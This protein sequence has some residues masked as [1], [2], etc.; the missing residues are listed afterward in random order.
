MARRVVPV[1]RRMNGYEKFIVL[2]G[3][4]VRRI[5]IARCHY[6]SWRMCAPSGDRGAMTRT[7]TVWSLASVC[8]REAR[9]SF[10]R[11][12]QSGQRLRA[13][14]CIAPQPVVQPVE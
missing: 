11:L 13:D 6:G 3:G 4:R 12:G 7:A 1:G 8:G 14:A 10:G 2:L 5:V 9:S